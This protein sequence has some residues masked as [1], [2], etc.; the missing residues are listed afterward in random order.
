MGDTDDMLTGVL[1]RIEPMS[2]SP[3]PEYKHDADRTLLPHL[4]RLQ[5]NIVKFKDNSEATPVY[6]TNLTQPT[7]Q[8]QSRSR[9]SPEH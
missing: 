4:K 7:K 9:W 2:S 5:E 8:V 1:S 6:Y 3:P